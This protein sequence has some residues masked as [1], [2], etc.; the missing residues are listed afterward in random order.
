MRRQI[1]NAYMGAVELHPESHSARRRYYSL[2]AVRSGMM[3]LGIVYHASSVYYNSGAW[4]LPGTVNALSLG[5]RPFRD[6]QTS[7]VL[8][9]MDAAF[10]IF[11]MPVFFVM[12]GFFAALLYARRG[13]RGLILNR[14]QRILVPLAVAWFLLVPAIYAGY[15]F[16][17]T[18]RSPEPFTQIFDY[19]ASGRLY[20][21]NMFH[22]WFLYD[23]LIFYALALVAVPLSRRV[24]PRLRSRATAAFR[25]VLQS[26]WRPVLLSIPT[27]LIFETMPRGTIRTDLTFIPDPRDLLAYGLFFA[28]GWLLYGN[29]D[30][31]PG[32][33]RHTRRQITLAALLFPIFMTAYRHGPRGSLPHLITSGTNAVIAWLCVFGLIGLAV[34]YLDRPAPTVRYFSDASYWLYVMHYPSVVWVAGALSRVEM[35]GGLKV[36]VNLAVTVPLLLVSYHYLVRP[37]FIGEWLNGRRTT[38]GPP[39]AVTVE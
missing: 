2:D 1:G 38:S 4:V 5:A 34:H 12:A 27:L 19:L 7:I 6:A 8:T 24:S 15:L 36:L 33:T 9:Y 23:L 13:P 26:T 18:A 10:H 30:L 20:N 16:A 35:A 29:A 32:F 28:F 21:N 22:L 17:A 14:V 31:L 39:I 25:R 11:R 3:L 37:T